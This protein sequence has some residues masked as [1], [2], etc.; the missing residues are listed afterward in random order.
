MTD[1][2]SIYKKLES[3]IAGGGLIPVY[4]NELTVNGAAG[5]LYLLDG[6][7]VFNL[8]AGVDGDRIGLVDYEGTFEANPLTIYP[9]GSDAISTDDL[10]SLEITSKGA[11]LLL[12]FYGGRWVFYGTED[13][14]DEI[15]APVIETLAVTIGVPVAGEVPIYIANSD[16]EIQGVEVLNDSG[17]ATITW[18]IGAAAI[19]GLSSNSVTTSLNTYTATGGNTMTAN[20]Q[21]RLQVVSSTNSVN[22]NAKIRYQITA[23]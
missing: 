8:P 4:S 17:S 12:V 10:P 14:V 21:L 15:G 20:E 23:L 5:N 18:K 6:T 3:P 2:R 9:D 13:F 11:T 1:L 7:T 22:L 19:A 16:I